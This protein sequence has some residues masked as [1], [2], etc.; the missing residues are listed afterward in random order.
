MSEKKRGSKYTAPLGK[1]EVTA[2]SFEVTSVD[3]TGPYPVTPSKNK[4]LLTFINNFTKYVGAYPIADQ[5]A[6]SC[7]RV[8]ATQILT[9]HKVQVNHG[10]RPRLH[11][12]F[13]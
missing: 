4:Y 8:Y 5:N 10:P 3:I 9:R 6:E 13:L 2:A 7:A 12:F 1:V 11:V